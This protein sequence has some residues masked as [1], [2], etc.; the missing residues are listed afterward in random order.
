MVHEK[1]KLDEEEALI[2]ANERH[3][4]NDTHGPV[5]TNEQLMMDFAVYE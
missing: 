4:L 5:R 3:G 2:R 1:E